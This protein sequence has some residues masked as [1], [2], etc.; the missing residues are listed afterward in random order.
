M[1]FLKKIFKSLIVNIIPYSYV[2]RRH[3]HQS[4]FQK[5]G[6]LIMRVFNN[7]LLR[8]LLYFLANLFS[9][10]RVSSSIYYRLYIYQKAPSIKKNNKYNHTLYE[11]DCG[12]ET[13][14]AMFLSTNEI[15]KFQVKADRKQSIWVGFAFLENYFQKYNIANNDLE[16]LINLK[17]QNKNKDLKFSFPVD[18]K[19]HGLAYIEKEKNWM[20][21]SINL[22]EFIDSQVEISMKFEFID[23]S[24]LMF[25]KKKPDQK[26][27]H[28]KLKTNLKGM[29]ISNPI[30]FFPEKKN[31]RI[32]YLCCESLTDPFFFEKINLSKKINLPNIK[33]ILSDSTHYKRSY[34][35]CDSTLPNIISTLSGL[36]PLQHGFGNYRNDLFHLELNEKIK[37]LPEL[38]KKKEFINAAYTC[39]GRFDSLYGYTNSFDIWSTVIKPVDNNAP[40]SNKIINAINFFK[41][42]NI[43]LY[44]HFDRLHG[45]M[46]NNLG[47]Q[48]PMMWSGESLSE[49]FAYKFNNLYADR[50]EI[51]DDEI[52]KIINYLKSK[53]L[54]DE[55]TLVINGDHG[56]A[57]PPEWKMHILK[58]P[59]YETHS[60]V[61]LII[62]H[63]KSFDN[64]QE[65]VVDEPTSSQYESFYQILKSQNL[66][67][68]YYF[69]N[70][71]Q[72]RM[73][74][75]KFT[76][77]ETIFNPKN[78]NYGIALTAQNLKLYRLFN[79]D[80]ENIKIKNVEFEKL[81]TINND[82]IV[83]EGTD[84]TI[85][86][87]KLDAYEDVNLEM[88]KIIKE[89][90]LFR[91]NHLHKNLKETIQQIL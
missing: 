26:L 19:K 12:I 33:K 50:L 39:G 66:D 14:K 27:K 40:S 44:T 28:K 63:K 35:F 1:L 49:A 18:I 69:E 58:Y 21:I 54:Y 48:S 73:K 74:K 75:S 30:I 68:P 77:S 4:S 24:F 45:P 61:P 7:N 71:F 90:N 84:K 81:F 52:G 2:K 38:L 56:A 88:E 60:R 85:D 3:F 47:L 11:V 6:I 20:D 23:K 25:P 15:L 42:Q 62:K 17:S 78:N 37:F 79:F 41:D 65:R 83:N 13:R 87:K 59:L 5:D 53:N 8:Y 64:H 89:N 57:L 32:I 51:L 9:K 16:I 36:S 82:G 70:L 67:L 55:T 91:K 34:S 46:L 43:F 31:E 29:A 80:W 10:F 72:S 86:Y 22:D 76:V